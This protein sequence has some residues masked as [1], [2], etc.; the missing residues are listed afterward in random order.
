[1]NIPPPA[2]GWSL[3]KCTKITIFP[4]PS[5]PVTFFLPSPLPQIFPFPF[6][7]T[8]CFDFPLHFSRSPSPFHFFS[9]LLSFP[10][11][12]S[13]SSN[14]PLNGP[15]D[16]LEEKI[17]G[18]KIQNRGF[19]YRRLRR[20]WY[21]CENCVP[22]PTPAA[23]KN[24]SVFL[25]RSHPFSGKSAKQYSGDAPMP[26]LNGQFADYVYIKHPNVDDHW[27]NFLIAMI[28]WV[29][30]YCEFRYAFRNC[31]HLWLLVKQTGLKIPLCQWL[32]FPA[33]NFYV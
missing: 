30:S 20:H 2:G 7:C 27:F 28:V 4:M 10:L 9:A 23:V 16:M 29:R 33:Y 13:V 17:N 8:L 11:F 12:F 18:E 14:I 24:Q 6:K 22:S 1:M 25:K 19:Y 5:A 26:G 31:W 15:M 21:T 32:V 3:S